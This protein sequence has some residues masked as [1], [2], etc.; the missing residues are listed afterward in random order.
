M[1]R[2]R[3][4]RALG[5]PGPGRARAP[6][7]GSCG[8]RRRRAT[9]PLGGPSGTGPGRAAHGSARAAAAVADE[10]GQV[11][12]RFAV[13]S[14]PQQQIDAPFDRGPAELVEPGDLAPSEV[15]VG[16]VL[17]R[18]ASPQRQRSIDFVEGG[19]QLLGRSEG[20]RRRRSAWWSTRSGAHRRRPVDGERVAAGAGDEQPRTVWLGVREG[21]A[22]VRH[23]DLQRVRRVPGQLVVRPE[24]IDSGS[25]DTV[26]PGR[27]S[28]AISSVRG[29]PR[30]IGTVPRWRARTSNGPRTANS[31]HPR[32][33]RRPPAARGRRACTGRDR[34]SGPVATACDHRARSSVA[35]PHHPRRP[36]RPHRQAAAGDLVEALGAAY[37]ADAHLPGAINIPPGQVDRLAPTLL[38]VRDA[39]G[40][41]V[42]QRIVQ[43]RRGR[44]RPPRSARLHQRRRVPRRQGGLGRT[45]PPRRTTPD[46]LDP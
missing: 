15:H 32:G 23:L 19:V 42:L 7:S 27:R 10:L 45:R 46:G 37:Y 31:T 12:D 6:R 33:Y 14:Q 2:G 40:G 39:A 24:Q 4:A 29:R 9:R 34:A 43:L 5:G 20:S 21:L 13:A 1:V 36:V 30:R 17:E 25:D 38:P 16:D 41:R 8:R 35:H 26:W 11:T 44:G 3:R 28:S 18:G 22:Q